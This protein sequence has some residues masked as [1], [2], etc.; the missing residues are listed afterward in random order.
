VICRPGRDDDVPFRS[1]ASR[2]VKGLSDDA[3]AHF[4]LDV[5]RPPTFEQLGRVLRR[6]R[7]DGRPYHVVHF[8]GH[9]AFLDVNDLYDAWKD[10]S[11]EAEALEHVAALLGFKPDQFSPD[12]I[13]PGDRGRGTRGYL[14][15]ENPRDRSN[16][17]LVD[18]PQLGALLVETS[19][20]MLVLNACRSAHAD[21]PSEPPPAAQPETT[22]NV[23]PHARVRAIGSLAQEV[24]DAGVGGVV[25][26]RYNVYVVT[27]AQFVADLYAALTQGR[28][29]GEAVTLGRKQLRDQPLREIAYAPRPLQDWPVPIVY[30]AAPIALFR[31]TAE[32][33]PLAITLGAADAAPTAGRTEGLPP[34]PDAGF[35]GRDETLL[36][37]DRAF[38]T[39]HVV[40]LHAYAGSGKT[41]TAAE[42]GRWY[43]LTGGLDGTNGQQG[44]VLFTS[45]EQQ[46]SLARVL[47]TLGQVFESLLEQNGIQWLALSDDERRQVALQ[48][49]A[50]V[51][52]L[53]IWDNIEGVAGFPEG[54]PS[55]WSADEQ[56]ELVDF[57]RDAKNS[58]QARFLLTSRRDE[59]KWLAGL[60]ARITVPQMPMQERVQL[61]RALAEKHSR[62]L[63]DIGDWRPLLRF[64]DGNPLTITV[65][66]GQALRDVLK[67]SRQIEA[68]VSRLRAGEAA[69]EDEAEEGRSKSLGASLS[70]GFEHAFSEDERRHLALLHQF[71][72]FVDVD[73]LRVIGNPDEDWC[74]P[75]VRGLTRETGI[76]LLDRA[77]EIGLLMAHGGGYYSIH[78][79]LP[80]YL[81]ALFEQH[82]ATSGDGD[83]PALKAT[84][85]YV[86]AMGKFGNYYHDRYSAGRREVIG[87]LAAEA[88]HFSDHD[89]V[90]L[91]RHAQRRQSR[92]TSQPHRPTATV[93]LHRHT[94]APPH[95]TT[96][97]LCRL[98]TPSTTT[99]S[100]TIARHRERRMPP[101]PHAIEEDLLP[102]SSRGDVNCPHPPSPRRG[103]SRSPAPQRTA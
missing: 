10:T 66:V 38:D 23:D 40:L 46:Q 57:L 4:D 77:A 75:E 71:Q 78:P 26:M 55:Q 52:I 95:L 35:F 81:R 20:P 92:A 69:F 5:L 28:S 102:L 62:Q 64:T 61:A 103:I 89:P 48:I 36:A 49:L 1:V 27:A 53:W 31:R 45:F 74:L 83:S 37:L 44:M 91:A 19:V 97:T 33:S 79:A 93:L 11:S 58:T 6:A 42:F 76:A 59:Q 88:G 30:E 56:R 70:Y 41:S 68:F 80:W 21:A 67:T 29:L 25:A 63:S 96:S 65:L 2:I 99:S 60:P 84:R 54:T 13:Y 34:P 9:G 85:T 17:R 90:L 22:Q 51:P 87:V 3:R 24:M 82:Y 50:Q 43:A 86:E 100:P 94:P 47:D 39:Q 14:A 16:L 73:A 12:T 8:D 101:H 72:G 98:R 15:F 7:D 32:A 18:G